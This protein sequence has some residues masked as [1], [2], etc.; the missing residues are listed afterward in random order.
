LGIFSIF[1]I[2]KGGTV[3]AEPKNLNPRSVRAIRAF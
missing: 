2:F 3:Q 1:E